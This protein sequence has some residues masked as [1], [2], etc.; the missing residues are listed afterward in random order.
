MHALDRRRAAGAGLR[1]RSTTASSASTA[2]LQPGERRRSR[3]R[4]MLEQRG[5][6]NARHADAHRRQRHL[7]RQL[8]VRPRLRHGRA[9]R[10]CRTAPSAAS[11]AC[12]RAAPAEARGPSG[13]SAHTTCARHRLGERRHHRHHRRRPDAGRARLPRQRHE[14]DGPA[15]DRASAPTRRSYNFFSIQ[16]ARYAIEGREDLDKGVELAVYYDPQHPYNVDRMIDAMRT[17]ARLLPGAA[18]RRY[19]FRQARILEFPAYATF[20]AGL[21]QHHAR[22]RRASASSPTPPEPEQDRLRHLRHRARARAPVVGA[23]DHRRRHAGRDHA[24]RD[25]RPVLGAARD[26]EDSTARSSIRK[27]LKYELDRYLRSARRRA[28]RGAAA[29]RASRTSGYIHYRRARWSMYLLQATRSAR[30]RSTARCAACSRSYAFKA[31][32]LPALARPR[33]RAARRGRAASTSS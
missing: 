30:P 32:A 1:P 33:R 10:C 26:G 24:L 18:S 31:R 11:T 2:P 25:P 19:Q 5:F 9:T 7:R 23:P 15:H 12:R 22:T 28:G 20:A 3:S 29:R 6:R 8:R 16:S 14:P 13:R 17:V 4:R 27:F 21:R